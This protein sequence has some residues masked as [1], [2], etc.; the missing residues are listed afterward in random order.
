MSDGTTTKTMTE[1]LNK[2]DKLTSGNNI[3]ISEDNV[4]SAKIPETVV[5]TDTTQTITGHKSFTEV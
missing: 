1:V 4:I 5:T 3:T 2:Q